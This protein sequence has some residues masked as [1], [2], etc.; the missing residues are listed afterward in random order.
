ML[1]PTGHL[2]VASR[3]AENASFTSLDSITDLRFSVCLVKYET[4]KEHGKLIP[5]EEARRRGELVP[6]LGGI[7]QPLC[8][9]R[10]ASA[11]A[12]VEQQTGMEISNDP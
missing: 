6:L 2:M 11:G 3:G 7:G 12:A 8:G 1:W 4:F 5:H 9:H 10:L